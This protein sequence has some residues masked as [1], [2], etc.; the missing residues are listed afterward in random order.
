MAKILKI[1]LWVLFRNPGNMFP[2]T[3]R[4]RQWFMI[5][6]V[7]VRSP[8]FKASLGYR[9][10][11]RIARAAQRNPVLRKQKTTKQKGFISAV[12]CSVKVLQ[13]T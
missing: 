1:L 2:E 7:H 6:S 4:S 11:S 3:M 10:S 12:I 9:V 13:T 5:K 8:K